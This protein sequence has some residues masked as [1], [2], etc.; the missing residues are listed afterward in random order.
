MDKSLIKVLLIEDN[1][2]DARLDGEILREAQ[3]QPLRLQ[4]V[5]RLTVSLGHVANEHYDVVLVDLT[6]PDAH[7]ICTVSHLQSAQPELPIVVLTDENDENLAL[8]AV[9]A[10]AQ[11]Y[12]VKGQGDSHLLSRALWYAIERKERQSKL[13]FLAQHDQLTELPNRL[14]FRDRLEGALKRAERNGMVVALMFIDLDRFKF[15][16]DTLGHDYGD[17]LLKAAAQRLRAAVRAQATVA[18]LGGDEFTVILEGGSRPEDA[19]PVAE[20]MLA[21]MSSPFKLGQHEVSVTGSIGIAVYPTNA[22]DSEELIRAADNAM[23]RVKDRGRNGFQ[24][25]TKAMNANVT[26]RGSMAVSLRHALARNEFEVHYQ[27]QVDL[28]S[29]EVIGLEALVRW[30]H[31]DLGLVPPARFLSVQEENGQIV[32]MGHW[33]LRSVCNQMQTWRTNNAVPMRVAVNLSA[34]ELKNAE[35]VP[36][37]EEIFRDTGLEPDQLELEITEELLREGDSGAVGALFALKKIGVRLA[38]D[39]FG[40]SASSLRCLR[41]LHIDARKIDQQL[42]SSLQKDGRHAEDAA[43]VDAII[44]VGHHMNARV[45]AEAVEPPRQLAMLHARGCD[46]AQGYFFSKPLAVEKVSASLATT[47]GR[48]AYADQLRQG[49]PRAQCPNRS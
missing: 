36:V 21:Q 47:D 8:Q 45:M 32:P 9:Q 16:N 30:R 35:L 48:W 49:L 44:S 10:G 24:F 15:V 41:R 22:R 39:D 27:P 37:L 18:R 5:E 23:Y 33:L 25:F 26:G 1:Q 29:G 2:Q 11:D 31:P 14:L 38:V 28:R 17:E 6:L 20:K 4:H 34:R 43:V 7:G 19:A 12:L 3:D 42:V 13:L 46:S 40:S